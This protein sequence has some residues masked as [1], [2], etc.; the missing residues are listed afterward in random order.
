MSVLTS[1]I[2]PSFNLFVDLNQFD[3]PRIQNLRV[4][5]V[6]HPRTTSPQSVYLFW[7]TF[8]AGFFF[9]L[10]WVSHSLDGFYTGPS[11]DVLW[12]TVF[13]LAS[14]QIWKIQKRWLRQAAGGWRWVRG[15]RQKLAHGG[16]VAVNVGVCRQVQI[17][18][19]SREGL[20][21]RLAEH[22][23]PARNQSIGHGTL[24]NGRSLSGFGLCQKS[25]E[26]GC[27]LAPPAAD[28]NAQ[29]DQFAAP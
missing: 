2:E 6:H 4:C 18:Q 1:S 15:F 16:G 21:G 13:I 28:F 26:G 19:G 23:A 29:D 25:N 3:Q 17:Q 24:E 14:L 12:R 5:E 8:R 9:L 10:Q 7:G 11:P 20:H 27:F 22:R